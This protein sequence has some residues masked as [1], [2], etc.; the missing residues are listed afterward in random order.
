MIDR[1]LEQIVRDLG[2]NGLLIIGLYFALGRF[3]MYLASSIMQ[4]S[5]S[6]NVIIELMKD[7]DL[8]CIKKS[9]ELLK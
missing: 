9:G 4:V 1:F 3:L 7:C 6:L 5:K 2:V 8:R